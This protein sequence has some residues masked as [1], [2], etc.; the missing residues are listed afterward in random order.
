MEFRKV[1]V[2]MVINL[3]HLKAIAINKTGVIRV[4]EKQ[5]YVIGLDVCKCCNPKR[6]NQELQS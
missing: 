5:V 6:V 1:I 3:D 4:R 2:K